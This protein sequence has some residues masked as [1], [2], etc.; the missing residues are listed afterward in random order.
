MKPSTKRDRGAPTPTSMQADRTRR[1]RRGATGLGRNQKLVLWLLSGEGPKSV[2][3]MVYDRMPGLDESAIRGAIS[4]LERRS[5]VDV[6]DVRHDRGRP[7]RHY[8]L[9]DEGSE[10]V[11]QITGLMAQEDES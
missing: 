11:R 7:V 2:E 10:V 5:L 4:G 3:N 8:G 6:F 9:T 1:R